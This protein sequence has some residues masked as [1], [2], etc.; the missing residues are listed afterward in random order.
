VKLFRRRPVPAVVRTVTLPRGE[1]RVGWGVT[2]TG[3]AVVAATGGLLLPDRELVPWTQVERATWQ[4]PVLT[5]VEIAPGAAPV[6]GA[7][8]TTVLQLADEAGLAEAVR[9]GVT[10]SVAWS[11]RVRLQPEGG[12]RVVGRRRPGSDALDWQVVYD[13]GTDVH[14][15]AVRAQVDAVVR[16]SRASIG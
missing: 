9:T 5:V 12:A 1:R 14:D 11:T 16:R 8:P 15:P 2:D 13:E 4:R 3:A 10:G 7:G 6:R